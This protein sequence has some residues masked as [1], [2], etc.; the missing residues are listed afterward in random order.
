MPLFTYST[1][2]QAACGRCK[3]GLGEREGGKERLGE[4]SVGVEGGGTRDSAG[5]RWR[6]RRHMWVG[7][8]SAHNLPI[9]RALGPHLLLEL[10]LG[11]LSHGGHAQGA[12]GDGLAGEGGLGKL[13]GRQAPGG[14]GRRWGWVVMRPGARG[15]AADRAMVA[16]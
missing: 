15:I 14:H 12:A 16:N 6:R 13:L 4:E 1:A 5:R 3:L 10:I 9:P 7:T 8:W 11:Q 2:F